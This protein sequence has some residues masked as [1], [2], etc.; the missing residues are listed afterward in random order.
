MHENEKHENLSAGAEQGRK[1]LLTWERD[2]GDRLLK[3]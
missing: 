3:G 1:Q 2:A